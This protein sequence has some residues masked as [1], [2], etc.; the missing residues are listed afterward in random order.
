MCRILG[1]AEGS[2]QELRAF[3]GVNAEGY[4]PRSIAPACLSWKGDLPM[5][6]RVVCVPMLAVLIFMTAPA[7]SAIVSGAGPRFGFS[8]DPDQLVLGGQVLIGEVAPNVTFDPNLELGFGDNVTVIGTSFDLHYHFALTNSEW[9]PYLGA[10]VGIHF[11]DQD[12]QPPASDN[13]FTE[14]G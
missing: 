2:I 10:G 7:E 13:T 8:L 14:V 11:F 1:Q 3:A 5:L 12:R 6:K 4:A 9:R